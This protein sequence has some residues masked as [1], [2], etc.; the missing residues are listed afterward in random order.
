MQVF[1]NVLN[2]ILQ[3]WGLPM[4][5]IAAPFDVIHCSYCPKNGLNGVLNQ[6]NVAVSSG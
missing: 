3:L 5:K 6:K 4:V 1:E 2:D